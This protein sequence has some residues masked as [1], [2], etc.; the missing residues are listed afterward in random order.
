MT[1]DNLYKELNE[2]LKD[3]ERFLVG[4]MVSRNK[5]I[6]LALQLDPN[7]IELL[8]KSEGA[9]E[10][11]FTLAGKTLVFDKVGFQ[12][13]VS[14]KE[15]L[16]DSYTRFRNKIGLLSG[17]ELISSSDDVVLSFPYKDCLLEGGQSQE[18][19]RRDE[20]F[21][22]RTLSAEDIDALLSP[23]ALRN[24]KIIKG[25]GSSEVDEVESFSSNQ[26]L[27]VK[28]NNLLTLHSLVG[29]FRSKI[30]LIYVDPPY[31][32]GSEGDTFV[33]NNSFKH[34]S[35]LV[36]MK[37]RLEI[38]KE[39]LRE[40]GFIALTIDHAELFYLGVLCDE[41]FGRE[42]R[43]GIVS[44]VHKP[45]GRNQEKFF[46]TSNEFML[47]YAKN[48]SVAEFER[49]ILDDEVAKKFDESDQSGNYRL[50]NFIR[51]TDGKYALR[52]NK[53]HFFYPIYV[54]PSMQEF[55]LDD[56]PGFTKVLP[57]TDKGVE[58]TWKTTSSTFAKLALEG[59]IV[60]KSESGGITIYEKLR[61]NQV[62]KTHWVK[63]EYH[64]YH[65]GTKLL[66]KL[67]G[68]KEFSFPKSL[69]SVL[70]TVKLMTSG[71]DI[72]LDF[73]AGSG[74][75]GHAVLE[76]NRQ[77]GGSRTFV[78]CEQ[79]DYINTVTVERLKAVMKDIPEAS[80]LYAELASLNHSYLDRVTSSETT[81]DLVEIWHEMKSSSF[82]SHRVGL[83]A[84]DSN[85]QAFGELSILEQ[86]SL[87]IE[88]LDHNLLYAPYSSIE[89]SDF[90][91]SKTEIDLNH[92]WYRPN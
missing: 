55:S 42:N 26:N 79:M 47:V 71:D 44:I 16:P 90:G 52:E 10:Q 63:K 23:K 77:D 24:F 57:I 15:F 11:F 84:F 87:L 14:N 27:V 9:K 36:F 32:T 80:I 50:K 53:P 85:I 20:F 51:L 17:N 89:D 41:I 5:V 58:R 78:L 64:A 35:W 83:S 22:N 62:I 69:Y 8:L 74:T 33:Y 91:F 49:V 66:E 18:G 29:K 12:S 68:T 28:G 7:L 30:K 82:L 3:D 48:K 38:A 92:E 25:S 21:W 54:S 31:N 76:L 1:K 88:A 46:G 13:F 2:I 6:E 34:S 75:T 43:I 67:L 19:S 61:E 70:D 45:E 60:A 65:F 56:K 73:F 40:D 59:N 37:N 4:G 72:V 39:F 81:A 86:K